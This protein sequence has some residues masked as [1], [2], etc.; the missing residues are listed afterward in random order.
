MK[1]ADQAALGQ[2]IQAKVGGD[3]FVSPAVYSAAKSQWVQGGYSASD[4]D[5]IYANYR[6][7]KNTRY[8][9]TSSTGKSIYGA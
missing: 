3:G 6:N 4:F 9:L 1:Q 5:K 8:S 2:A 7:P